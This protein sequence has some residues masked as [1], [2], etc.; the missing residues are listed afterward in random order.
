MQPLFRQISEIT[1]DPGLA[2][3]IGVVAYSDAHPYYKAVFADPDLT[4]AL[5]EISKRRWILFASV[6]PPRPSPGVV[7]A[8]KEQAKELVTKS[9]NKLVGP[10][11][12]R[13]SSPMSTSPRSWAVRSPRRRRRASAASWGSRPTM[14]YRAWS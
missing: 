8:L 13:S 7:T 6:P 2:N 4:L 1:A 5:N 11:I 12:D 3:M 10:L 9:I 14:N